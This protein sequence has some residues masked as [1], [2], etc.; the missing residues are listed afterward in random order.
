MRC[1]IGIDLSLR[2]TGVAIWTPPIEL[3][4]KE[5]LP[6]AIE[7]FLLEAKSTDMER[8]DGIF[9]QIKELVKDDTALVLIEGLAFMSTSGKA[10][11]RAGLWW[12]V[13]YWLWKRKQPY[14]A[15]APSRAKKYLTGKGNAKKDEILKEVYRRYRA[16]LTDDN[17]ADALN[18]CHIGLA[19]EGH[20]RTTTQHQAEVVGILRG[21]LD[22]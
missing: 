13:A 9:R 17:L 18:L 3:D 6:S 5:V 20:E 4:H 2:A 10:S 15:V 8:L 7:L 11:E 21:E 22:K 19:V 12:M 1:V 16:D 14:V